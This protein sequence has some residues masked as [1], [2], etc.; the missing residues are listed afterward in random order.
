MNRANQVILLLLSNISLCLSLYDSGSDVKSFSSKS[1]FKSQVLRGDSIWLLEFYAPWCG[2]CKNLVPTYI[3]VASA[4]KGIVNVGAVDATEEYGQKLAGEYG[5]QGFPTIKIF[6]PG[7]AGL[8]DYQGQRDLQSFVKAA[9][10]E[11]NEVI[12]TRTGGKSSSSGS[13]SKGSSKFAVELTS[14]NFQSK[15]LDSQDVWMVAFV[16]PWC[17]H[18]KAL[19]PEWEEAAKMVDGQGVYL[20]QVDATVHT[21][22]AQQYGVQGYP[23]IKVFPGGKN[24]KEYTYQSGRT[25]NDIVR[26]ALKEVDRS[27]A[28]LEIPQLTSQKVFDTVCSS[29]KANICILVGLPHIL[30]SSAVKR[31]NYIATLEKIAKSF[32]GQPFRFTWFEGSSQ[33]E[34]EQKLELTFGFPAVVAVNVDKSV[35]SVFRLS[36]AEKSVSTFLYSITTGRAPSAKFDVLPKLVDVEAWDGKDGVPIEEES[37]ADI[38]GDDWNTDASCDSGDSGQCSM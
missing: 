6:S 38:M 14:S 17:G 20:G 36:F 32:R 31:N 24:S 30:D 19:K 2:H 28:P 11:I 23:T 7:K 10:S 12:K 3:K 34:L 18:C 21:D 15:V 8:K 35:Y 37:L 9:K 26:E 29:G 13:S 16:A 27:G 1:D 25:K 5:V 4:L 33:P 22:L